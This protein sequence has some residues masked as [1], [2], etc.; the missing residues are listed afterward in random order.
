MDDHHINTSSDSERLRIRTTDIIESALRKM[1]TCLEAEVDAQA[2][3]QSESV[4]S[5]KKRV[6]GTFR[7]NAQLRASALGTDHRRDVDACNAQMGD[8]IVQDSK[9]ASAQWPPRLQLDS[10][11]S[12]SVRQNPSE[13][14]N[15]SGDARIEKFG[16][17]NVRYPKRSRPANSPPEIKRVKL[18]NTWPQQH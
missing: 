12:A 14:S 2:E 1:K 17:F 3:A 5:L 4:T 8:T 16:D 10:H 9:T 18:S 13:T 7:K 15:A 6:A 11:D